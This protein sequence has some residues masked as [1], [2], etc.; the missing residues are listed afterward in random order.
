[1]NLFPVHGYTTDDV[2]AD[3]RFRLLEKLRE[4]GLDHSNYAR[5]IVGCEHAPCYG[6]WTFNSRVCCS[7]LHSST[8]GVQ[9]PRRDQQSVLVN[10]GLQSASA[11]PFDFPTL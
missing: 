4:A 5:F 3:K 2:V 1:M 7:R 9:A 11:K 6:S 10:F 8:P